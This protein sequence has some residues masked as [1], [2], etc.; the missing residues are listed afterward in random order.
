MAN[1]IYYALRCSILFG[2]WCEDAALQ[3]QQSE[4]HIDLPQP[5]VSRHRL[6]MVQSD[7]IVI[8]GDPPSFPFV[9]VHTPRRCPRTWKEHQFPAAASWF[10]SEGSKRTL[11]QLWLVFE[12]WRESRWF[13]QWQEWLISPSMGFKWDAALDWSSRSTGKSR[14]AANG[15]RNP[16]LLRMICK[17]FFFFPTDWGGPLGSWHALLSTRVT[18]LFTGRAHWAQPG[19]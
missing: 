19:I 17:T 7:S 6:H 18:F 13:T 8:K 10:Y 16:R 2:C 1:R 12:L 11:N 3:P 14:L 15:K 9:P 4:C 5:A